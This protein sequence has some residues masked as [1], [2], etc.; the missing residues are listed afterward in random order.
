V[1]AQD[2]ADPGKHLGE[3]ERLGDIVVCAKLKAF[4]LV[5]HVI[6]RGEH[7]DGSICEIGIFRRRLQDL[8]HFPA[9]QPGHDVVQYDEVGMEPAN[10]F[11]SL[12]AVLGKVDI[13]TELREHYLEKFKIDLLVINYQNPLLGV[14]G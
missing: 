2:G 11:Q 6:E 5:F 8:C 1:G 3:I 10:G 13:E 9:A 12:L 14:H 7:D 4:H